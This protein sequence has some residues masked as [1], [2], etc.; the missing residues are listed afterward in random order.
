MSIVAILPYRGQKSMISPKGYT[1]KKTRTFTLEGYKRG[2]HLRFSRRPQ[3]SGAGRLSMPEVLSSAVD[4]HFYLLPQGSSEENSVSV[5]ENCWLWNASETCFSY[6]D[7]SLGV[8]GRHGSMVQHVA[9]L[10]KR[11]EWK[12]LRTVNM[13]SQTLL[14]LRT[15]HPPAVHAVKKFIAKVFRSFLSVVMVGCCRC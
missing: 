9:R 11:N 4:E 7:S 1:K 8:S 12:V 2:A 15:I 10:L 14:G 6:F 5:P 13:H 3:R